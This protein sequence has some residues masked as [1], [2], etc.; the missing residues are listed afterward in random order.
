MLEDAADLLSLSRLLTEAMDLADTLEQ[1]LIAGHISLA[2][3]LV[4][5]QLDNGLPQ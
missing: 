3:E 2:I 5:R 4:R 1:H